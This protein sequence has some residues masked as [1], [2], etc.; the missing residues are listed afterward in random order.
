[1][2]PPATADVRRIKQRGY[3]KTYQ[4]KIKDDPIRWAKKQA[5][6]AAYNKAYRARKLA[7][8]PNWR[9]EES[10]AAGR[11]YTTK[12]KERIKPRRRARDQAR[13]P[14]LSFLLRLRR[15]GLTL[16]QFHALSE[17]QDFQCWICGSPNLTIDHCH[18]SGRVRGLLCGTCNDGLGKFKDDPALLIKAGEYLRGT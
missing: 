13:R 2:S 6:M 15:Y 18:G 4:A 1:M 3:T 7:E 8:D 11:R 9:R 10:R 17:A 12:H 16:D 5:E 14:W